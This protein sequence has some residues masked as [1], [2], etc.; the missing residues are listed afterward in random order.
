[1][2]ING[3]ECG[4]IDGMSGKGH[5]TASV[6]HCPTQILH[7][8]IWAGSRI[9]AV[10]SRCLSTRARARARLLDEHESENI[11]VE[12]VKYCGMDRACDGLQQGE[13]QEVLRHAEEPPRSL[14]QRLA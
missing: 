8:L 6:P 12:R 10:G 14:S 3:D 1:M 9:A 2:V 7:D 11:N 5:R 4:A 13:R